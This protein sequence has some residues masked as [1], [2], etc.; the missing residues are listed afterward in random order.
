[1]NNRYSRLARLLSLAQHFEL[2]F[3]A[4]VAL[5]ALAATPDLLNLVEAAVAVSSL[6]LEPILERR[7]ERRALPLGLRDERPGRRFRRRGTPRT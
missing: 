2:V 4:C 7:L 5:S 3:E 6:F 1:M